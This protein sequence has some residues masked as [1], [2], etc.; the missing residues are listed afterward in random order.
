MKTT[1]IFFL[2][3][4]SSHVYSQTMNSTDTSKLYIGFIS[5]A[6]YINTSNSFE[7]SKVIINYCYEQGS[8]RPSASIKFKDSSE[9][10]LN[11]VCPGDFSWC[12]RLLKNGVMNDIGYLKIDF[13]NHAD[14]MVVKSSINQ[15]I[16]KSND[17]IKY[18]NI[19]TVLAG[20]YKKI[21]TVLTDDLNRSINIIFFGKVKTCRD[22][23]TFI[24]FNEN[25]HLIER[26][27]YILD[28]NMFFKAT[29]DYDKSG[30]KIEEVD[31][32]QEGN[33]KKV[34]ITFKYD[35]KGNVIANNYIK[36]NDSISNKNSW[37]YKYDAN[38]NMIQEKRFDEK[39]NL[40]FM[41]II[42]YNEKGRCMKENFYTTD[43]TFDGGY[44]F[45]DDENGNIIEWNKLDSNGTSTGRET[46]KFDNLNNEI[47]W[48]KYNSKNVLHDRNSYKY[49]SNGNKIEEWDST[50]Y[51]SLTSVFTYKF[52]INGNK[53]EKNHFLSNGNTSGK[54]TY[55]YDSKG[56]LIQ[57]NFFNKD[58]SLRYN[59]SY[60]YIYDEKGNWVKKT[61]TDNGKQGNISKREIEYY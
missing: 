19:I 12:V 3:L 6:D 40:T 16:L 47:E 30:N 38:G 59:T 15:A 43:S 7:D 1:L 35:D 8:N 17:S 33:N 41:K 45:N 56:N 48:C 23:N 18:K 51:G 36:D 11:A 37:V 22:G 13:Y 46:Y 42:F 52:D 61:E 44:T 26:R 21:Q 27:T 29:Y 2:I 28:G 20:R 55:D 57:H 25:G 60:N 5:K 10:Y 54:E 53:V 58:G 34:R 50:F 24:A 49:D 14:K 32:N 39:G 4:F 9:V 31:S